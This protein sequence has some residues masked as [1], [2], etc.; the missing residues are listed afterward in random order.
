MD[1]RGRLMVEP[2]ENTTL[3]ADRAF[4]RSRRVDGNENTD[5]VSPI[6]AGRTAAMIRQFEATH[7]MTWKAIDSAT[8][9]KAQGIWLYEDICL[10]QKRC[11]AVANPYTVH[12][13]RFDKVKRIGS[14]HSQ[15]SDGFGYAID[16]EQP[17]QGWG[18]VHA[19]LAD[20]G[21][22]L[23]VLNPLEP[24]HIEA[25]NDYGWFGG[26][27]YR[28]PKVGA[29][30]GPFPSQ[31]GMWRV[32]QLGVVGGDVVPLQQMAGAKPDGWFGADTERR[33][34]ALQ[35]KLGVKGD[36]KWGPK[37]QGAWEAAQSSAAAQAAELE[38]HR[39]AAAKAA[40]DA[41]AA[42]KA[43]LTRQT[44]TLSDVQ[45]GL[46]EVAARIAEIRSKVGS[47]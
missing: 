10:R 35:T 44:A 12:A 42:R 46:D 36:G 2:F 39:A 38:R 24:W 15:H 41:D 32:L 27:T 29:T 43:A 26:G 45:K 14:R 6:L 16:L 22:A 7:H 28:S 40:A 31:P 21:L 20:F 25:C 11:S 4:L 1:R 9:T 37:S 19:I 23:T 13:P 3:A 33:V 34:V 17:P 18:A 47:L 8:R 5:L 30:A